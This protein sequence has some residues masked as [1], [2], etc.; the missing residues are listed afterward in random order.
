M[1]VCVLPQEEAAVTA[2]LV[3][4][5]LVV[6]SSGGVVLETACGDKMKK[7]R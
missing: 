2:V 5:W 6:M 7:E 3:V 1:Q 4:G